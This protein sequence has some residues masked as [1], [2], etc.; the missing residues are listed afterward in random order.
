M[1]RSRKSA[2]V[3]FFDAVL[4]LQAAQ[5]PLC[6]LLYRLFSFFLSFFLSLSPLGD[7]GTEADETET[8]RHKLELW[9]FGCYQ[10]YLDLR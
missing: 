9:S 8:L 4:S 7:S 3:C 5:L 10:T 6:W 2:L 1:A